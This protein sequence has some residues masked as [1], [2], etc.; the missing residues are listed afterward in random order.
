VSG[1]TVPP[2]WA[3]QTVAI[4]ASGESMSK[5]VADSVRL[6][7]VPTIAINTTVELAPW[8]DMLYAADAAWWERHKAAAAQF[9]GAKVTCSDVSM[10]GVLRLRNTGKVGFDEDRSCVRTGGNGGYQA[11][12]IAV[13]AGAARILLFGYDMRGGHWHGRHPEPLRNAGESIY[14]RWIPQYQVLAPILRARGVE[15]LNCTPGS[16]LRVWPIVRL[17][18]AMEAAPS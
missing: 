5:E 17:E 14:G 11:I 18:E 7:G 10:P 16:A 1:W 4:L 2:M 12:H 9:S 8:A 13:H 6:L 15:V 3:G